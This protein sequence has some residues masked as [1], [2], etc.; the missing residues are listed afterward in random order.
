KSCVL[1]MPL[2]INRFEHDINPLPH[3]TIEKCLERASRPAGSTCTFLRMKGN[4]CFC[5]NRIGELSQIPIKNVHVSWS[6]SLLRSENSR[7][8]LT[9]DEWIFHIARN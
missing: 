2:K 3:L 6:R 7:S 5:F 8:T 4:S 9:S 1:H